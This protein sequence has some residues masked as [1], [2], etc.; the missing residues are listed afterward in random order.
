MVEAVSAVAH[1]LAAAAEVLVQLEIM[2]AELLAA[3][4]ALVFQM[5]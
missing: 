3:M 5:Q 1:P 2:V 4:A